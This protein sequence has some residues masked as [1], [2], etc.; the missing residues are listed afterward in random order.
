AR[1][2]NLE[3]TTLGGRAAY[4]Y[5]AAVVAHNLMHGCQSEAIARRTRGEERLENPLQRWIVHAV[6]CVADVNAD[7]APRLELVMGK[8]LRDREI[9]HFHP[10]VDVPILL[11]CLCGIVAEI[12]N[13]LL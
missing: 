5:A 10:D 9:V 4:V 2:P 11:D 13:H 6:S 8:S 1:Q 7:V 3:M 12:E